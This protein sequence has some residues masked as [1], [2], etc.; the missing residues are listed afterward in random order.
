MGSIARP[1]RAHRAPY[2]A[3][4]GYKPCFTPGST[5]RRELE[6]DGLFLF[7]GH[8]AFVH[9]PA[10]DDRA[11]VHLKRAVV[12]VAAHARARLQLEKVARV[13]RPDERAVHDEMRHSD[14][15]FDPSL[16]AHDERAR[17]ALG[18]PH[19]AADLAVD[20]QPPREHHV[21]S[22]RVPTPIRLSIRLCGLVGFFPNIG[23]LSGAS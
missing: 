1:A 12:D 6:L 11:E 15:A 2:P 17:L 16:L 18:R 5:A 4:R 20:A 3:T 8:R 21:A 19:V 23:P 7:L 10:V 22:I 9:E 13:H 14:L